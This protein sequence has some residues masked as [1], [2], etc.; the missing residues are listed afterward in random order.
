MKHLLS[1]DSLAV[2]TRLAGERTLCAFD[3]D[4]TLATIVDNP[5]RASMRPRTRDMLR[6]LASLY[7]CIILSGRARKNLLG[8]LSGVHVAQ[9]IGNHG[10]ETGEASGAR[11]L[12]EQWKSALEAKLGSVP[13]LWIEDKDLSLA[14]HYR[15]CAQKVQVRR[16][17]RAAAAALSHARIVGGKQVVN[18]VADTAPNKGDALAAERDRLRCN[19]VL[20]VGD[21]E[22]DEAAFA[23]DGNVVSVRVGR[24][25]RS[26]A[27]FYLR[28]QAE[29]DNLLA[30]LISLRQHN[31]P[32]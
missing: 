17:I 23:L 15:L 30:L 16:D 28:A 4:G 2:I 14:V 8:K 32:A 6:R 10:A 19:W 21:D 22:N 24:K 29:V 9:V 12:V 11:P 1:A 27:R 5:D 25:R 7:P 26:H 13:G 20:Y 18:I 3:F 31:P